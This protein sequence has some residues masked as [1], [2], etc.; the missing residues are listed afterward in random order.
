MSSPLPIASAAEFASLRSLARFSGGLV[1]LAA[2][3]VVFWL[4]SSAIMMCL[5]LLLEIGQP[6]QPDDV[7]VP[8]LWDAAITAI[9][10]LAVAFSIP[11]VGRA[12]G[13]AFGG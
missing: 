4:G 5:G 1:W 3:L 7:P 10:A 13:K 11:R 2:C 12:S 9:L 6:P 8:L